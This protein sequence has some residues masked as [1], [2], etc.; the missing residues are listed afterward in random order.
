MSICFCRLTSLAHEHCQVSIRYS[1]K[2]EYSLRILSLDLYDYSNKSRTLREICSPVHVHQM[3]LTLCARRVIRL[4]V[5]G[6]SYCLHDKLYRNAT[7]VDWSLIADLLFLGSAKSSSSGEILY[8]S[9]LLSTSSPLYHSIGFRDAIQPHCGT[10]DEWLQ[11]G[12][13]FG[14][15]DLASNVRSDILCSNPTRFRSL[16][17]QGMAQTTLDK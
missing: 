2:R 9:P 7:L 8:P 12:K 11:Q 1:K 3:E 15:A 6:Q 5:A 14:P 17:C 10:V 16:A 13:T 4:S